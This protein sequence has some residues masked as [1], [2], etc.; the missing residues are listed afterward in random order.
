MAQDRRSNYETWREDW[1]KRFLSM[2]HAALLR[3]LPFLRQEQGMILTPY[4]NTLCGVSLTDGTLHAPESLS[5]MD[6]MNIYTL[7]WYAKDG[8]RLTS[9]FVPFSQLKDASPYGPAFQRG[10]LAP[11]AAAFAGHGSL[12]E[13]ALLTLNGRKLPTGDVGYEIRPFPC[14]PMRVLFWD[15]DEEF[16]A[17]AN[18]LFD[19]SAT[20]FIHVESVVSIA[21][22]GARRL[23]RFAE[24]SSMIE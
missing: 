22:E 4:F 18:L 23:A 12:L 16:P 21:S 11:L 19:R 24:L 1:R 2:D 3:K 14:V 10:N 13:K 5:L 6:E 20:D 17:Q 9:E 8:A 15:G 7:F